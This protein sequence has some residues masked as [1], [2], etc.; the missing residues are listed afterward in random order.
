MIIATLVIIIVTLIS[1]M[2]EKS[3]SIIPDWL[4]ESVFSGLFSLLGIFLGAY[5][6][7]KSALKMVL[8]NIEKD[9]LLEDKVSKKNKEYVLEN[10]EQLIIMLDEASEL[11]TKIFEIEK[12]EIHE[13]QTINSISHVVQVLIEEIC[14]VDINILNSSDAFYYRKI[15]SECKKLKNNIFLCGKL[16]EK[17]IPT[18]ESNIN[19]TDMNGINIYCSN[20]KV[21]QHHWIHTI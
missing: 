5:L 20:I 11:L 2:L 10:T 21:F 4:F 15:R 16:D 17:F 6:A 7:S 19:M 14:V 9:R 3:I 8:I 13:L 1:S 12:Y 18:F